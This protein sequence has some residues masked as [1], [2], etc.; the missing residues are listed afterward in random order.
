M[1]CSE[2]LG[3]RLLSIH[4][5][6]YYLELMGQARAAIDAGVYAAFAKQKLT[7]MDRHEHG[8]ARA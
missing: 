3:P 2:P 1:K 7:E 6:H 8:E 4:N 5:L